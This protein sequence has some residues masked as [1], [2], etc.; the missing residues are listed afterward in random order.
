MIPEKSI[1]DAVPIA[2]IRKIEEQRNGTIAEAV[3]CQVTCQT[4]SDLANIHLRRLTAGIKVVNE[5]FKIL[6]GPANETVQVIRDLR[7]RI[8]TPLEEAK[9]ILTKRLMTWRAE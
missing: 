9:E 7:S 8:R 1:P 6:L 2:A 5:E 3:K 4:D